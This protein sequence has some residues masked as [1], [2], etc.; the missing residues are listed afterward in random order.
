MLNDNLLN[1]F[2]YVLSDSLLLPVSWK[3]VTVYDSCLACLAVNKVFVLPADVF[4][5]FLDYVWLQPKRDRSFHHYLQPDR[6]MG[7][8]QR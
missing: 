4:F 2:R 8:Q 6:W 3:Y 5:I 7:L 1:I